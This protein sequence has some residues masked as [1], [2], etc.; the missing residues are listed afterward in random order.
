MLSNAFKV[1]AQLLYKLHALIAAGEGDRPLADDIRDQ[2][3]R[4]WHALPSH[5]QSIARVLS[6]D[7]YDLRTEPAEA[8]KPSSEEDRQLL[9]ALSEAAQR[10]DWQYVLENIRGVREFMRPSF[11]A[12]IRGRAWAD[13]GDA[14]TAW[15]FFDRASQLDPG[16]MNFQFIALDT[17][18]KSTRTEDAEQMAKTILDNQEHYHPKLVAKAADIQF[19]LTRGLTD[20]AA[21]DA[22]RRLI[23]VYDPLVLR[24]RDPSGDAPLILVEALVLKGMCHEHLGQRAAAR[25]CYDQAL[26][27]DPYNEAALTARGLLLYGQDEQA[28]ADLQAACD[29]NTPLAWPYL[30]LAHHFLTVGDY[31]RCAHYCTVGL[32]RSPGG[33]DALGRRPA[34]PQG[35]VGPVRPDLPGRGR[36]GEHLHRPV[37]HAGVLR[38]GPPPAQ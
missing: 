11:A 18:S 5:E 31:G 2:M 37:L 10:Q 3:D 28:L 33:P 36:P 9:S 25:D 13:L 6:A 16:D 14:D 15:L 38:R 8:Q 21:V 24:L 20:D 29:Q 22:Y 23:A 17:L 7:L 34:L 26:R 30:F 12:Y 32:S 4:P 27:I 19:T 1:F 35:R